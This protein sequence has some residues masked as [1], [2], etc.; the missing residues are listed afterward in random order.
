MERGPLFWSMCLT[1]EVAAWKFLHP[2][3]GGRACTYRPQQ[4]GVKFPLVQ[5]VLVAG[6]RGQP[7]TLKT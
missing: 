2:L 6:I 3:E 5:V 4:L 7:Q 1:G